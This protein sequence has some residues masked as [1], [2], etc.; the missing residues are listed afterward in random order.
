MPSPG[1]SIRLDRNS[2]NGCSTSKGFTKTKDP[3]SPQTGESALLCYSQSQAS[4]LC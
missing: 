2:L 4:R 3:I 1:F